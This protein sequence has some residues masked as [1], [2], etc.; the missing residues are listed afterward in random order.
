M[1]I[2]VAWYSGWLLTSYDDNVF[3]DN[4]DFLDYLTTEFK[5][6]HS[7]PT[8]ETQARR[9]KKQF[10]AGLM[11]ASRFFGV[12]YDELQAIIDNAQHK[13][14]PLFT[15]LDEMLAVPA[16]LRHPTSSSL[17]SDK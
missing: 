2:N 4:T 12:E 9:D 8:Q 3:M 1:A 5:Q 16:Y 10:I 15:T 17:H 14:A 11:T 6:Y 7:I 13:G